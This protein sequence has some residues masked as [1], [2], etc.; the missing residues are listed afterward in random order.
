MYNIELKKSIKKDLKNIDK[1]T[2]KTIFQSIE[3]LKTG[4]ED[5]PNVIKLQGNNPYYRLR[6][7]FYRIIFEKIDDVL[8]IIIIKIGHR[9][10]VYKYLP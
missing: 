9:G 1:P 6:V 2:I 8:K 7:S 5:N 4:I 10:D 3:S